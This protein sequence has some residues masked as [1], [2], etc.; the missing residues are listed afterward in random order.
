MFSVLNNCSTPKQVE[1]NHQGNGNKLLTPD[2]G[3]APKPRGQAIECR[4]RLGGLLKYY[5]RA[6]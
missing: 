1:R 4:Q 6:A 5:A 2:A 3:D